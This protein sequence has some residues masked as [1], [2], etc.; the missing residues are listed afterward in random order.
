[1]AEKKLK[2]WN[3]RMSPPYEHGYVAA[4]S[5]ADAIRV[6]T[7]AT[8]YSSRGMDS[9]LKVYWHQGSW[10]TSMTGIKPERGLW[11]SLKGTREIVRIVNGRSVP[12]VMTP[13]REAFERQ[14]REE[15]IAIEKR[16][17]DQETQRQ[18]LCNLFNNLVGVQ[19]S[20][21]DQYTVT[22]YD[23]SKSQVRGLA[24]WFKKQRG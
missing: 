8:G 10:G 19:H 22:F 21:R 24:E 13:E 17:R 12:V 9:E 20:K 3:G 6:F 1:M 7:E 14:Q 11:A 4:Y 15:A 5:R 16:L 18:E 2:L 23:L